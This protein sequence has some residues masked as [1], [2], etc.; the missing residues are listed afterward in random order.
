MSEVG[1]RLSRQ[2]SSIAAG[3]PPGADEFVRRKG[4]LGFATPWRR[5]LTLGRTLRR[6]RLFVGF[7]DDRRLQ[8]LVRL[9]IITFVLGIIISGRASKRAGNLDLR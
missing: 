2:T 7:S 6:V 9:G 8:V 4:Y 5:I 3:V 1:H